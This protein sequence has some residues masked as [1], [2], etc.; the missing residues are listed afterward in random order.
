MSPF[1]IFVIV[2]TIGYILYYA[3]LITMDLH[4]KPKAGADTE[5]NIVIGDYADDQDEYKPK[6][7]VENPET[8]GFNFLEEN[9][10]EESL[11][12]EQ[13]E[14]TLPEELPSFE[15]EEQLYNEGQQAVEENTEAAEEQNVDEE[16]EL[17]VLE[18]N[19]EES[20]AQ[21]SPDTFDESKA[22]DLGL[23]QPKFGVSAIVEPQVSEKII[24]QVEKANASNSSIQ[25]KGNL[26]P[27]FDLTEIIRKKKNEKCNIDFKD[28]ITK[29]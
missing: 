12:G 9:M 4:A 11:V 19:K 6:A 25:L 16:S 1:L 27:A 13:Q 24:Q 2:L 26:V 5:E 20:P 10:G 3:A 14:E 18:Y 8:G 7:V 29:C 21:E 23:S 28:E 22:F 17:S 15:Y